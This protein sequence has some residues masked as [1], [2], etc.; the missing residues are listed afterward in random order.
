MLA[1]N[2]FGTEI[3]DI[4]DD[5]EDDIQKEIEEFFHLDPVPIDDLQIN[6]FLQECYLAKTKYFQ[7]QEIQSSSFS[8]QPKTLDDI[9]QG[10]FE[11]KKYYS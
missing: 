6:S 9:I 10:D 4:I 1:Q 2:A 11:K 8:V 3:D 5:F 7:N